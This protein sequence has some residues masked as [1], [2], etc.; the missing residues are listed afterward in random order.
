MPSR[1]IFNVGIRQ[2]YYTNPLA[3]QYD[4]NYSTSFTNYQAYHYSAISITARALPTDRVNATLNAEIDP[5]FMV[6]RS[7]SS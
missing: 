5:R 3:S 1:E 2:T 4:R 6:L 7:L